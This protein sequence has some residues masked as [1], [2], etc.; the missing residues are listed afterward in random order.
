MEI[1]Y[2]NSQWDHIRVCA[3]KIKCS[4]MHLRKVLL[5]C[6]NAVGCIKKRHAPRCIHKIQAILSVSTWILSCKHTHLFE[7][8]CHLY[9][10]RCKLFNYKYVHIVNPDIL[11][12][13]K[14]FFFLFSFF[15]RR[16]R[17]WVSHRIGILRLVKR[18]FVDTS[19]L[20]RC[21]FAFVLPILDYCSSVLRS[22]AKCLLPLLER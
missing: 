11:Y 5:R 13:N 6:I 12:L 20:L 1:C 22:A 21:Y 8:V 18:M 3:R 15:S 4:W 16:P 2:N 14:D 19:V 9:F 7:T 10:S 17:A